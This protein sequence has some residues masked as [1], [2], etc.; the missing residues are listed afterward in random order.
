MSGA[1]T[2]HSS[3]SPSKGRNG[4][5]VGFGYFRRRGYQPGSFASSLASELSRIQHWRGTPPCTP[6]LR[7]VS[8]SGVIMHLKLQHA[9]VLSSSNRAGG[10]G[11]KLTEQLE[12]SEANPSA[13]CRKKVARGKTRA[14][15]LRSIAEGRAEEGVPFFCQLI[16]VK[17]KTQTSESL[18]AGE[19]VFLQ[20]RTHGKLGCRK[21]PGTQR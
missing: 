4:F 7:P 3:H 13:K 10:A 21:G 16:P 5:H 12:L 19:A 15:T 8:S 14:L 2:A 6:L 1:A 18:Y 11:R 9:E 20:I 17:G